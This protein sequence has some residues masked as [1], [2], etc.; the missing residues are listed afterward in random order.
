VHQVHSPLLFVQRIV[1]YLKEAGNTM[2]QIEEML[3]TTI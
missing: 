1:E 2:E 3:A